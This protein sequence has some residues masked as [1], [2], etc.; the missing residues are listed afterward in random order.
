MVVKTA[1]IYYRVIIVLA[2]D[3]LKLKGVT[4]FE[5]AF[6]RSIINLISAAQMVKLRHKT[7]FFESMP[8]ELWLTLVIRCLA[9]T[10]GFL[11]HNASTVYPHWDTKDHTEHEYIHGGYT[12]LIVARGKEAHLL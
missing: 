12:R 6:F 8:T 2:K 9:G 11:V 1:Q 3:M 4:L 7:A 5:F 10:V